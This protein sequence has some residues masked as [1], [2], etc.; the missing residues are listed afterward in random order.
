VTAVAASAAGPDRLVP[1][2]QAVGIGLSV[3]GLVV[4]GF[5][6]GDGSRSPAYEAGIR[7]GDVITGVDGADVTDQEDLANALS[8]H[9]GSSITVSVEREGESLDLVVSPEMSSDGS[10]RLGLW[11]RDGLSGIGTVTFYDP[12]SHFYGA[13][14]HS[15]NDVDSGILLPISGGTVVY[16][17]VSEVVK[18]STGAPGQLIGSFDEERVMGDVEQNTVYGIFGTL[19]DDSIAVRESIPVASADEVMTGPVK[20]LSNVRGS[21][22]VQ[23]DAEITRIA[24]SGGMSFTLRISDPELISATGGIVQ[25]MSGSPILQNGKLVGAV[26]HVLVND[27]TKGYGTFI[28]NMTAQVWP[29]NTLEIAG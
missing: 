18:S 24:R 3:N 22:I 1:V 21:E 15:V 11:L 7:E 10:P 14:G 19:S 17:T 8:A 12:D 28:G 9:S 20:I 4:T 16:S 25:G 13:L 29:D 5:D 26:T 2:G 23:Y 27:S 6:K